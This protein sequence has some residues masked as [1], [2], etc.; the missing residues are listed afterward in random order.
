M[1][2]KHISYININKTRGQ[3]RLDNREAPATV[4]TIHETNT[5]NENKHNRKL[6]SRTT[7]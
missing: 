3:L 7:P 5:K 1:Q 4:G 6:K 2:E